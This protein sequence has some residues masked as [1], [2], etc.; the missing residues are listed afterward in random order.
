VNDLDISDSEVILTE[1]DEQYFVELKGLNAQIDLGAISKGYTT[2]IVKN[3]LIDQN[4]EYF[5]ISAGSST[6]A[7]GKNLNRPNEG[8]IFNVALSDPNTSK[9]LFRPSY[10]LVKV[11]DVSVTTSGNFEQYAV[12]E[13]R[14]YHHIISPITKQPVSYYDALTV[15]GSNAGLLDALSTALFVM[16]ENAFELFINENQD[17]LGIEVIRYNQDNSIS[18]YLKDTFFEDLR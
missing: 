14:R 15:I 2:E 6:I 16:D 12:F 4:V 10:G 13:G 8:Y 18:T 5:S 3:Y 1:N 9:A 17:T 11:K 7:L